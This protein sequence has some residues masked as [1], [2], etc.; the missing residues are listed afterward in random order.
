MD[1]LQLMRIATKKVDQDLESY[2]QPTNS[3][4]QLAIFDRQAMPVI[5]Q[6]ALLVLLTWR[7]EV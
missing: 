6:T 1:D 2:G 7:L 5:E 4:F 3:S